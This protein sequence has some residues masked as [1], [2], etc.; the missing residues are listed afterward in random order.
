MK[1]AHR[2]RQFPLY[3][4]ICVIA[5]ATE[6]CIIDLFFSKL[7]FSVVLAMHPKGNDR[8]ASVYGPNIGWIDRGRHVHLYTIVRG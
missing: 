4:A 6:M 2:T 3:R 8:V 7:F 1:R 5:A